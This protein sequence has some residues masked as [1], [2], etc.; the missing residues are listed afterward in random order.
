MP[1][2]NKKSQ[3]TNAYRRNIYIAHV[4]KQLREKSRLQCTIKQLLLTQT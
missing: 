3:M 2:D 4:T 1:K